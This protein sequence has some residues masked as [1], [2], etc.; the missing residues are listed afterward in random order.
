MVSGAE[1]ARC[2]K[3]TAEIWMEEVSEGIEEVKNHASS[4]GLVGRS[5][6][7]EIAQDLRCNVATSK[8]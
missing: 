2:L 5:T 8:I 4:W 3:F 7:L 6:R 1:Y